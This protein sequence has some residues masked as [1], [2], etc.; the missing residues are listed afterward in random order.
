MFLLCISC[1]LQSIAIPA[2]PAKDT[3]DEDEENYMDVDD[4]TSR[5]P[6]VTI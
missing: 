1:I 5:T 6:G 4:Y 2:P 3:E